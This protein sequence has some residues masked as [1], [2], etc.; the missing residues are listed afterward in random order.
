MRTVMTLDPPYEKSGSV[1][2][3][4]GSRPVTMPRLKMACQKMMLPTPRQAR[5][6]SGPSPMRPRGCTRAPG[7]RRAPRARRSHDAPLLGEDGERK[8]TVLLV[9][10]EKLVL[11]A[12]HEA[13]A[14]PAAVADGDA[15]SCG[16]QLKPR[17]FSFGFS[18]A[19]MR[20]FLIP[21][22]AV[23]PEERGQDGRRDPQ[24]DEAP[25]ADV[26]ERAD[27]DEQRAPG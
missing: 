13:L 9:Q 21:A 5:L 15:G 17:M 10:E 16:S 18:H 4:T 25:R 3:T 27:R 14:E 7:T 11:R 26:G 1:T 24:G 8:V 6:R 19:L 2:P 22:Q 12:L 23:A 20:S